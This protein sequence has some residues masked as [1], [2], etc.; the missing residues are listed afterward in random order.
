[1]VGR[2]LHLDLLSFFEVLRQQHQ[3]CCCSAA[4]SCPTLCNPMDCS[5]PGSPVLHHLPE[6]DKTHVHGVGD[7][8][9]PSHPLSSPSPPALVF[10]HPF[11]QWVN[12]NSERRYWHWMNSL[13]FYRRGPL[14]YTLRQ[15]T[16]RWAQGAMGRCEP[17][18][19]RT[20]H[21]LP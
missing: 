10:P 8:A 19:P 13:K 15:L 16:K 21:P 2:H 3:F 18:V 12:W 5:T 20:V 4:Q 6:L 14:P 1:M 11:Y 9:Q 17:L 7:A